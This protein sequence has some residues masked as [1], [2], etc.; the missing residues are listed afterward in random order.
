MKVLVTGFDAFDGE[1]IN[2]STL[3]LDGLEDKIL[4]ADIKSLVLPTVFKKA[5]SI[6]EKTIDSFRPDILISLGQAGGRADITIER[7]AINIDD[8]SIKDNSG[9][10][11]VDRPIREDGEA[12]Y[13]SKLPIKAI[14]ENL[15][16]NK[17]PSSISNTAGTYVCNHVMYEGLYLSSRYPGMTSG[18]I[19]LPYLPSQ[20]L[21]K[22]N[23][24]S[25]DIRAMV[26]AVELI[27]ETSIKYH[28][29]S[30]IKIAYGKI[31]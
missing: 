31:D 16:E 18:F 10:R 23:L 12:A 6:L 28:G 22:R 1:D 8:A 19:H 21:G 26:R 5:S 15:K 9:D 7:V 2:P 3:V 25:M 4:G 20:V 14:V 27:I 13:F 17:I 30:D 24:A 11:P 29:K